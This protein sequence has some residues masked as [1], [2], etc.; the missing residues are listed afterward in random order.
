MKKAFF[1]FL[2]AALFFVPQST[3]AQNQIPK[4][5][6]RT[7]TFYHEIYEYK[8]PL[9]KFPEYFHKES[10]E[11]T[12]LPSESN[13]CYWDASKKNEEQIQPAGDE[14]VWEV[15]EPEI[16][17]FFAELVIPKVNQP[18]T[19][20][21][22]YRDENGQIAFEGAGNLGKTVDV[23]QAI[24][25][26]K[27]ALGAGV[28]RIE[29]PVKIVE[30]KVTVEDEKL[31]ELGIKEI[32][33]VGESDFTGSSW[34]RMQNIEVGSSQFNGFLIEP[35]AIG[36]FNDR[37]GPVDGAHGYLPELVIVGPKLE[38]EYG[39]GLCQVSSTAFRAALLA[40][41]PIVERYPHSFA[42]SYYAPF[43][44]DATI[45]PGH[46]D[47]RFSNDTQGTILV[48]TTMD[49]ENKKLRF[50][51]YGSKDDRKVKMFGPEVGRQVGPPPARNETST[52][53]APGEVQWLSHAVAGFDTIWRR[54]LIPPT[55]ATANISPALNEEQKTPSEKIVYEFFSRYQA[56]PSW[57]VT[58]VAAAPVAEEPASTL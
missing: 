38:K 11:N 8:L 12:P 7:I 33:S 36:S 46:K 17:K 44:T 13:V 52:K 30:P 37:L 9:A 34:A 48:Q 32:V 31:R 18:P 10:A 35:G 25:L 29:L 57:K 1:P 55:N 5:W 43:G 20:V 47:L 56:R 26:L 27:T 54:V 49:R 45:Y 39:G 3:W 42:V 50:H 21:R 16:E 40:G 41:L 2:L 58:G 28:D 4:E 51:F 6:L 22:I 15:N 24:S 14:T 23:A 19:D 53:L